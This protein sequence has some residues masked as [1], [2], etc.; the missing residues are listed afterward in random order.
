MSRQLPEGKNYMQSSSRKYYS[1]VITGMLLAVGLVLPF[2][3]ANIQAVAKT[4]SP[5]HIPALICG[6][7]CGWK[8]GLGLGIVLPLLRSMVFGLPAFPANALPMAFELA[9]Y[10][11]VTGLLYPALIKNKKRSHLKAIYL[12]MVPAMIL[13]RFAGGAAKAL[14]MELGVIGSS[15]PYTFAAFFSAYFVS[16]AVGAVIHLILVPAAVL[17]VERSGLSPVCGGGR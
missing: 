16:T 12:S 5:L 10:G 14:F 7:C 8:W 15:S 17:A 6:L 3:T 4:I 13:G 1:L 2:I 9:V 11:V